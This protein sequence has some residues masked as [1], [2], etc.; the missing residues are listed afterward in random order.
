[1][2][3]SH[4][5][6]KSFFHKSRYFFNPHQLLP[7]LKKVDT[8]YPVKW[9]EETH[10]KTSLPNNRAWPSCLASLNL[11][12]RTVC[13]QNL[14]KLLMQRD[15]ASGLHPFVGTASN[16]DYLR[17]FVKLHPHKTE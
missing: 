13:W 12:E 8:E 16:R 5:F 7:L 17:F 10:M 9:N 11:N 15:A 4:P 14:C 3:A 6:G 2:P 1:M